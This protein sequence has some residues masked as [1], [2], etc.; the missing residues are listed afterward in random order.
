MFTSNN[1]R[2]SCG[3]CTPM[4]TARECVC[5]HEV[6]KVKMLFEELE[7]IKCIIDHP[8]FPAAC[9]NTYVLQIAYYQYRQ[10]Y[11]EDIADSSEYVNI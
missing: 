10:Q 1:F 8:G 11:R 7:D 3:N 5:C 9:L 2:C 6:E 4:S